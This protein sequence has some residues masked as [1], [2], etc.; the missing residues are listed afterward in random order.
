MRAGVQEG[1]YILRSDPAN[2]DYR[3]R[4]RLSDALDKIDTSGRSSFMTRR[5]EYC[6]GYAPRCAGGFCGLRFFD[7]VNAGTHRKIGAGDAG[8]R[9][10]IACSAR[11]RP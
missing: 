5:L 6:A 10:R 7:T 9:N 11:A 4:N 2:R 1:R 3:N 8:I